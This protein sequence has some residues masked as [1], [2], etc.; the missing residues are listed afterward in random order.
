MYFSISYTSADLYKVVD[1]AKFYKF[2]TKGQASS[3]WVAGTNIASPLLYWSCSMCLQFSLN[4]S[5]PPPTIF[6]ISKSFVSSRLF[7]I[8]DWAFWVSTLF[9]SARTLSLITSLLSSV[10]VNPLTSVS[11]CHCHLTHV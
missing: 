8:A 2:L 11:A 7:I 5:L 4:M 9:A 1:L 3:G 10:L 6:V